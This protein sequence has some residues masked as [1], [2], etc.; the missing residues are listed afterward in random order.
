MLWRCVFLIISAL[1]PSSETNKA[2]DIFITVYVNPTLY[3]LKP[4]IIVKFCVKSIF[5]CSIIN[6]LLPYDF[7]LHTNFTDF[8]V[9]N[10]PNGFYLK[11]RVNKN[12]WSN[13]VWHL[14]QTNNVNIK[15]GEMTHCWKIPFRTKKKN[16]WMFGPFLIITCVC[17]YRQT[18]ISVVTLLIKN[19]NFQQQQFENEM[20]HWMKR[21]AVLLTNT[22]MILDFV[23][24][25]KTNW[26]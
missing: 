2:F 18:T 11:S 17:K 1:V 24:R 12:S 10:L 13:F 8:N 20:K 14:K 15:I 3:L 16:N 26:C 9:R 22:M 7:L 21:L 6:M 25:N 5:V 4:N 23:F 19:F